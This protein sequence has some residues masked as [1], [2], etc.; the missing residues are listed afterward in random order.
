MNKFLRCDYGEKMAAW[1][2]LR[3]IFVAIFCEIQ[4]TKQQQQKKLILLR[5]ILK[6]KGITLKKFSGHDNDEKL[7]AC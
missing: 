7:H 6:K 4:K 5:E 2:K 3:G 1:L